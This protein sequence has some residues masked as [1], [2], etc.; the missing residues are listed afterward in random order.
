MIPQ[1]RI[2]PTKNGKGKG[3]QEA[4]EKKTGAQPPRRALGKKRRRT[5]PPRSTA[6]V[7][8]LPPEAAEMGDTYASI[9]AAARSKIKLVD[10]GID[11]LRFRIAQTGGRIFEVAGADGAAKA[12]RLAV[13]LRTVLGDRGVRVTRPIKMAELRLTGLHDSVIPEKIARAIAAQAQCPE[14]EAAIKVGEIHRL[15]SDSGSM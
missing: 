3:G 2:D 7:M 6:V 9:M 12:D 15:P 14:G 13:R 10:L 11:A 1:P 5:R 8:T 4:A